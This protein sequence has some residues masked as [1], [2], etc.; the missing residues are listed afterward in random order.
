MINNLVIGHTHLKQTENLLCEV[1]PV[2]SQFFVGP[3]VTNVEQFAQS[4]EITQHQI[5]ND[6]MN[7][8]EQF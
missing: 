2:D 3:L 4:L 8:H 6:T 1:S 7:M 5:A